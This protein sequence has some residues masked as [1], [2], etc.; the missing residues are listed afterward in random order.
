MAHI[1]TSDFVFYVH[2]EAEVHRKSRNEKVKG[3]DPVFRRNELL[4]PLLF[5]SACAM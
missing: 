1:T 5:Q 4:F 2:S 3:E